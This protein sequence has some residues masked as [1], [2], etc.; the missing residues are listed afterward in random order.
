MSRSG[1]SEDYDEDFPNAGALYR[2]SVD[3]AL[4]GKRGQKF[5]LELL[6][7]LDAMPEKRLVAFAFEADGEVCALGAV[8]RVKGIPMPKGN[9]DEDDIVNHRALGKLLGIAPCMTQEIMFENDESSA[10]WR[11]RAE[12]PEE[13]FARMR[14]W[15]VSNIKDIS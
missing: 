15:V 11:N 13:R 6:A 12:T 4:A 5:L 3:S 7:S 14:A 8:A 10:Y 2:N 1:Y 9:F